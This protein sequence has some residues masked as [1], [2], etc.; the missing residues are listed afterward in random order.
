MKNTLAQAY[1]QQFGNV[2]YPF[3]IYDA[4]G[5]LTYHENSEGYWWRY[6]YD[7]NGNETYWETS[8]GFWE[9]RKYDSNGNQTYYENSAGRIEGQKQTIEIDGVEYSADQ[10]RERIAELKPIKDQ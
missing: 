6:E 9:K 5:K 1:T 4:N 8:Y 2:S 10:V 3:V 7:T